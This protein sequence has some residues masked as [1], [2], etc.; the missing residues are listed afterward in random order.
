MG[1]IGPQRHWFDNGTS[2][3]FLRSRVGRG[4][5]PRR[6]RIGRDFRRA[7]LSDLA[8]LEIATDP[9]TETNAWGQTVELADRCDLTVY[10]AA[11][12]E[13]AQR[14]MLPLAT[15][16]H[17]LRAAARAVGTKTLGEP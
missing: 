5:W 6:G 9:H 10:D 2:D 16:D 1:P 7:A 3:R 8:M 4:N 14:R 11:Y 13:L 17:E 15:L 12:L